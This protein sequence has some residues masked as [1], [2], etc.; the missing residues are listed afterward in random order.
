M[1]RDLVCKM[2]DFSY[3][4]QLAF[5]LIARLDAELRTIILLSLQVS[6]TGSACAF[7]IG[8]PLGTALAAH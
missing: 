7:A 8:A 2:N 5:Q 6:L 3:A 1:S 4:L